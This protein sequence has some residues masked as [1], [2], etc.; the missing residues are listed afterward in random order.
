ME[1]KGLK[2]L[3]LLFHLVTGCNKKYVDKLLGFPPARDA[4]VLT[5]VM[6]G[7]SNGV[8][9]TDNNPEGPPAPP[10]W[11]RTGHVWI[12]HD[13]GPEH[14]DGIPTEKKPV[15]FSAAWVY[16]GDMIYQRTGREVHFIN[17]SHGNTSTRNWVQYIPELQ[18]K[19]DLYKPDLVLWIQGE[20]DT[21]EGIPENESYTILKRIMAVA[22]SNGA[23]VYVARDC[24]AHSWSYEDALQTPIRINEEKLIREGEVNAGPD[25]D[26]M[27][28]MHSDWF[29]HVSHGTAPGAE[30]IRDGIKE[31]AKAWF[32]ILEL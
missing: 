2:I 22:R 30:F 27:R 16:L 20:S 7:Q 12:T 10:A 32:E 18:A 8:S 25:I 14:F 29:E 17:A 26:R 23:R 6:T 13:F 4:H 28:A 15:H 21:T 3:A 31:H 11:S 5:V 24:G 1:N 19:V 9:P